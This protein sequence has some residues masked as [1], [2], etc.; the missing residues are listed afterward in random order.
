M[1]KALMDIYDPPSFT[2]QLFYMDEGSHHMNSHNAIMN[3]LW[4]VSLIYNLLVYI[5]LSQ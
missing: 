2:S 4:F 3:L 1:G 5:L